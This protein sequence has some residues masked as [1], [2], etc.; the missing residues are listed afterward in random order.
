MYAL[1]AR[2][3]EEKDDPAHAVR[4]AWLRA[5]ESAAAVL[6]SPGVTL[7][8]L[9]GMRVR[10]CA[11]SAALPP[12][13]VHVPLVWLQ[14]LELATSTTPLSPSVTRSAHGTALTPNTHS[15]HRGKDATE[16]QVQRDV[17]R[18]VYVV[19]G[20]QLDGS[21][22]GLQKVTLSIS[23][24]IAQLELEAFGVGDHAD[25]VLREAA[26]EANARDLR[27]VVL[28]LLLLSNRTET[29]YDAFL[30][31]NNLVHPALGSVFDQHAR[32]CMD[33]VL[34]YLQTAASSVSTRDAE[35]APATSLPARTAQDDDLR[36]DQRAPAASDL[37]DSEQT[38]PSSSANSLAASTPAITP[39]TFVPDGWDVDDWGV[40]DMDADNNDAAA[41]C[42]GVTDAASDATCSRPHVN[43]APLGAGSSAD[44]LSSHIATAAP[45]APANV[46]LKP[47]STEASPIRLCFD[48]GPFFSTSSGAHHGWHV[49]VRARI[50]AET[51]YALFDDKLLH[52]EHASSIGTLRCTTVRQFGLLPYFL[53]PRA[54]ATTA[55]R[56][57]RVMAHG[58]VDDVAEFWAILDEH[59][60]ALLARAAPQTARATKLAAGK[61]IPLADLHQWLR[62][63]DGHGH[64]LVSFAPTV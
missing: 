54:P 63:D 39:H 23:R 15:P 27:G 30:A 29:G 47:V 13:C 10:D 38:Q 17:E 34:P 48:V 53:R 64:V 61:R 37:S 6:A 25:E 8:S 9:T 43:N 22:L 26:V 11:A 51:V 1:L 7:L 58:A 28:A 21:A 3:G 46:V 35:L 42:N 14:P 59:L 20:Q 18:D 12:L 36:I 62:V 2:G 24:C 56:W 4:A 19:N 44:V 5:G 57:D 33:R 55:E 45:Y 16:H 40:D 60:D 31:A 50:E 49:G 52:Q 32:L 41:I